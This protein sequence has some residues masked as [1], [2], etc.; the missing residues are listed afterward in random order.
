MQRTLLLTVALAAPMAAEAATFG[1]DPIV[2]SHRGSSYLARENTLPAFALSADQGADGFELDVFLTADRQLAVFHDPDLNRLTNV[3]DVFPLSRA[4]DT[5]G[6]GA[7]DTWFVADFTMAELRTLEIDADSRAGRVALQADPRN[8]AP[9]PAAYRIPSYPE[10]LDLA[11]ARG[12]KVLTEVKLTDGA[13]AAEREA[14]GD[15]LIAEWQAR[16]YT[17]AS[18]PVVV[19]S[20]S[21]AFMAEIDARLAGTALHVP[22][23][24]LN[25]DA[26]AREVLA[27]N[28]PSLYVPSQAALEA[29]IGARYGA[30]DGIAVILDVLLPDRGLS[31]VLN[32]LGLDF[33]AAAEANGLGIFAWTLRIDDGVAD[34]AATADAY[35]AAQ[36]EG[37]LSPYFGPYLD[38]YARGIDG[39]I[40]DNPD[41]ALAAREAQA[42][43]IPLPA[44]GWLL[45]AGVLALAAGAGRRHRR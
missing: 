7:P 45:G 42:A 18:S 2:W 5:D 22:T 41:I 16:G 17:D 31:Q 26:A 29:V 3:E 20:F 43:P 1:P 19:Q 34:P 33:I 32:P 27:T 14:V 12:Q 38:L 4:R 44:A 13:D 9:Q 25:F 35:F 28:D 39:V 40:T 15:L 6:D 37:E 23:V 24:Q 21:D 30:L 8:P 36:A 10:A 11:E